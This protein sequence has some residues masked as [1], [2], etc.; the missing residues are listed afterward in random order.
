MAKHEKD[1]DNIQSWVFQEISGRA[2]R[3]KEGRKPATVGP[4]SLCLHPCIYTF[5]TWVLGLEL[6]D[7]AYAKHMLH[8]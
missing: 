2:N 3:K 4:M 5:F 1:R 6:G 8:H 7:L